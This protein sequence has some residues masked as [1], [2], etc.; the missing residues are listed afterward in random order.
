[1]YTKINIEALD[2]CAPIKTFT[3]KSHYKFG[4][5]EGTKDLIAKRDQTRKQMTTA[6][7]IERSTL[8][9][10]YKRIRNQ[11]NKRVTVACSNIIKYK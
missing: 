2:V 3:I 5:S 11:V 1:M 7:K 8:L 9:Q 4:L 10:Q 6:N